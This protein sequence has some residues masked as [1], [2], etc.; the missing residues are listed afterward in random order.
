MTSHKEKAQ[1]E[2]ILIVNA[3]NNIFASRT[4]FIVKQVYRRIGP[5]AS[6][7]DHGPA[8]GNQVSGLGQRSKAGCERT[9]KIFDKRILNLMGR[10][11]KAYNAKSPRT[12]EQR[13]IVMRIRPV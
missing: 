2:E 9:S 7:T 10:L 3:N 5:N 1:E 6:G 13:P 8:C 11:K 12:G 4:A